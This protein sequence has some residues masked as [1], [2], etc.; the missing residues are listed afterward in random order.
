MNKRNLVIGITAIV[1][2]V[3]GLL[4]AILLAGGGDQPEPEPMTSAPTIDI[5]PA[6]SAT[7]TD[8][9]DPGTGGNDDEV[10]PGDDGQ[11]V[12]DHD[13][14]HDHGDTDDCETGPV[15]CEDDP[16][17]VIITEDDRKSAAEVRD[18]VAP[19]VVAFTTVDSTETA[20]QRRARLTATG[21][22]EAVAAQDSVFA[23][24]DS[25]QTGLIAKSTPQ[26]PTRILFIGRDAGMLKFQ[27]SVNVDAKYTL[28]D[29]SGSFHTAGGA[30]YVWL[31]DAGAVVRVVE[32]FP[33]IEGLR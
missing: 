12:E 4:A 10:G 1:A 7:P 5:G 26:T 28:A 2:I 20:D 22:D 29:A 23:R 33:T 24:K 18:R 31:N 17:M 30:V 6:P 8:T 15:A 9:P 13:H 27:A 25:T 3:G 11:L 21:A 14:D 19:F 32:S 16:G